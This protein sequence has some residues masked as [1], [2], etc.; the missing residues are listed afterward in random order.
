M[1][2]LLGPK[3]F[4]WTH[5]AVLALLVESSP[6]DPNRPKQVLVYLKRESRPP[7]HPSIQS[8]THL[9]SHRRHAWCPEA[10]S[11][12]S[13][14]GI[15][16]PRLLSGIPF[17]LFKL[18]CSDYITMKPKKYVFFPR[19]YSTVGA[20]VIRKIVIPQASDSNGALYFTYT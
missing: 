4:I 8:F 15:P 6:W 18:L 10:S 2:W 16:L 19:G 5:K 3:S 17:L 11:T 13:S 7:P 14:H 20:S 1:A 9:R 12:L